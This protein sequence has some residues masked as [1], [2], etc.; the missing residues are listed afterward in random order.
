[1][2][3]LIRLMNNWLS[4]DSLVFSQRCVGSWREEDGGF[5][6]SAKRVNLKSF[7]CFFLVVEIL[8][9][10]HKHNLRAISRFSFG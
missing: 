8:I 7:L 5:V 2:E 4:T 1:M 10:S 6:I 3:Y 9:L